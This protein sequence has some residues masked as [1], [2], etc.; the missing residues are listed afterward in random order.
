M[1]GNYSKLIDLIFSVPQGS[2]SQANLFT[3]YCSLVKDSIPSPMMLSGFADD[4]SLRKS[5]PA[6][7][8]TSE[9]Y[10]INTM[11]NTLTTMADWMASVWLKLNGDKTKFIMFGSRQMLKYANTSHLNFGTTPM[12]YYMES[13]RSYYK[14]TIEYKIC[15]QNWST[16]KVSMKVPQ[17]ASS[18]YTGS[19]SSN[20]FNIRSW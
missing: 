8:H 7:C 17:N 9:E 19:Q 16:T 4:H 18:N 3:C 2:C 5:F 6:K 12:H 10:T 15:V 13:P 1:N 20:K 11:E 14:N